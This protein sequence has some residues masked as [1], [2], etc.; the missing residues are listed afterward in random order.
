MGENA[1]KKSCYFLH[2]LKN[3]I[4]FIER[5]REHQRE[6]ERENTERQL[7]SHHRKCY[8]LQETYSD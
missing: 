1:I 7:I 3:K 4:T 2:Q 6:I 8:L 5:E